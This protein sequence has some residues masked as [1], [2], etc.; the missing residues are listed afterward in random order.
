MRSVLGGEV[1]VLICCTS[2]RLSSPCV[3]H[4][5]IVS[6][7]QPSPRKL[8]LLVW[9][10]AEKTIRCHTTAVGRSQFTPG[11]WLVGSI[12]LLGIVALA[13]R[14]FFFK[15]FSQK[16]DA[17]SEEADKPSRFEVVISASMAYGFYVGAALMAN[18]KFPA[19]MRDHLFD[20]LAPSA[21]V[22]LLFGALRRKN[23]QNAWPRI[24]RPVGIL[25]VLL[26]GGALIF[27]LIGAA[28]VFVTGS[29]DF[30]PTAWCAIFGGYVFAYGYW[31]FIKIEDGFTGT[32]TFT[33]WFRKRDQIAAAPTSRATTEPDSDT[34]SP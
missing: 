15:V 32:Y 18:A 22:G 12:G 30:W 34:A 5:M 3:D 21:V 28:G 14:A 25:A 26:V 19:F 17:S 27:G 23:P 13:E 10:L 6:T 1:A 8:H 16:A 33:W 9:V 7:V 2:V 4:V 24:R 31:V 11:W 20:G 29:G